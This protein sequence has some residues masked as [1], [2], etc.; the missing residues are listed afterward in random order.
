MQQSYATF[1]AIAR[2][3]LDPADPANFATR[4]RMKPHLIQEVIDDA[5]VP[6]IATQRQ[7]ALSG[8]AAN[9][10][11]STPFAG[12]GVASTSITANPTQSKLVTYTTDA[13]HTFTHSSLLKPATLTAPGFAGTWRMQADF[14]QFLDNN[15]GD[16]APN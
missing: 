16:V 1:S 15:D 8:A 14:A 10:S 2:W 11:A 6:N 4:L 12:P 7:A 13:N 9:M 5:V 3:V